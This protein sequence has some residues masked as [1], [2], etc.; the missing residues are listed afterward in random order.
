MN[1]L[2]SLI[3]QLSGEHELEGLEEVVVPEE[4][5]ELLANSLYSLNSLTYAYCSLKAI[6]FPPEF[7]PFHLFRPKSRSTSKR[8]K[9]PWPRRTRL[10]NSRT[11]WW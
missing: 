7:V 10:P 11:Q 4:Y 1:E 2:S 5:L 3:K 9:T 6:D 8:P